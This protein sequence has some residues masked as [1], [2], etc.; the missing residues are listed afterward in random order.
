MRADGGT[1][2]KTW[3]ESG[4]KAQVSSEVSSLG[5]IRRTL[6][7]HPIVRHAAYKRV[8]E[9]GNAQDSLLFRTPNH[10]ILALISRSNTWQGTNNIITCRSIPYTLSDNDGASTFHLTL[11][12]S[13]PI[14]I[15]CYL[16]SMTSIAQPIDFS[17]RSSYS[18]A[19]SS[20]SSPSRS[21]S[22]DLSSSP[23]TGT[24]PGQHPCPHLSEFVQSLYKA[25]SP[26]T[27]TQERRRW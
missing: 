9:S 22:Y 8:H 14:Q 27:D 12:L 10:P 3:V 23:R 18:S 21:N 15:T 6:V 7:T 26:K 25:W 5:Q 11:S 1:R 4:N 19:A 16:L 17:S 13:L 24:S 2:Q 20:S